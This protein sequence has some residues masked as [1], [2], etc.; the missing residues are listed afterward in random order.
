MYQLVLSILLA[1]A[2][3]N[4]YYGF[5]LANGVLLFWISIQK[6]MRSE[7][8]KYKALNKKICGQLSA[9]AIFGMC[10]PIF[11]SNLVTIRFQELVWLIYLELLSISDRIAYMIYHRQYSKTFKRAAGVR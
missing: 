3:P 9:F 2:V 7:N 10:I 11:F 4:R 6:L 1:F 8:T 5:A